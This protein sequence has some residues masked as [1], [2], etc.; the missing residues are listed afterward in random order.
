MQILDDRQIR[1]KIKRLAI[2]IL[3]R[4][5]GEPGIILAGLNNNGLG[6]A[7]LLLHELSP[8]LPDSMSITLTRIQLNPANPTEYDPYIEMPA[9]DLRG[10]SIIIVDDVANTGRTIFYAVQ[11]LLKVLPA[12]VEVAVLVD[13]KHKSFPIKADYVGLSLYTTLKDH[14]NVQISDVETMAV[15]LE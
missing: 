8:L 13:R 10:K 12:R 7:Q 11:P 2:E 4:H 3:E 5:F 15:Y 6:F 9:E 14:I 1:Q